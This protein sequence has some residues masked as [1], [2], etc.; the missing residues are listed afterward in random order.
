MKRRPRFYGAALICCTFVLASCT[1]AMPSVE[2]IAALEVRN[3]EI[4]LGNCHLKLELYTYI[5]K[6]VFHMALSEEQQAV[7]DTAIGDPCV[8]SMSVDRQRRAAD[9][10]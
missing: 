6:P 8:I 9:R 4:E 5:G 7:I 10:K 1:S 2:Y 3:Q